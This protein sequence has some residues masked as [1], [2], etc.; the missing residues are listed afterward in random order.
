MPRKY[1]WP[2]AILAILLLAAG[3]HVQILPFVTDVDGFYHIRH[4]QLYQ[5]GGIFQTEFPWAQFSAV[6]TYAADLWYGFHIILI[7]FTLFSDLLTGIYVGAFAVTLTSL[8][9]AFG[10]FK[11][12]QIAWP[13]FWTFV[14]AVITADLMY[15]LTMLRP[16][17]LSLGL[18]LLIFSFIIK[19][20]KRPRELLSTLAVAAIFTWLHISLAWVLGIIALAIAFF[21]LLV[22][23]EFQ[24][25]PS[26]AIIGGIILGWLMRPNPFGALHLAYIQVIKLISVKNLPLRFG[27]ELTPF[28]WENFVDQLIPLTAL[29]V[30]ALGLFI[31]WMKRHPRGGDDRSESSVKIWSSLS[32]TLLFLL[33]TFGVARR[34]NE[35]L[36]AFAI[37]FIALIFTVYSKAADRRATNYRLAVLLG[38]IA[39]VVAPVKNIYRVSTY[40][41]N[42]LDP[43][44]MRPASNW[45]AENAAPGEIAYNVHWDRFAELFFWNPANYYIN[46]MDPIFEYEYSPGLYWE[47][48]F[49]AIDKATEYTC[50]SIRCTADE[51]RETYQALKRDFQASYIVLEKRRNPGLNNYLSTARLFNKTFENNDTVIYKIL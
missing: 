19:N 44:I 8:L 31:T 37:V 36:V 43:L 7:P 46:G 15:R 27:R 50:R 40:I 22:K 18:A 32:M 16:H 14:Y 20:P 17:P 33:M 34:T 47:T 28:V 29:L 30:L 39:L 23:R 5:S 24:W 41:S 9:L 49:Y 38:I 26:V 45:I 35:L 11:R 6:K 1:E 10:A 2:I 21:H 13:L 3:L 42:G 4:A 48:H 51:T 25:R 12:L